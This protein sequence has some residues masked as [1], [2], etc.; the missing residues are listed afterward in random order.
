MKKI[1][2]LF[3]FS[4]LSLALSAQSL[5]KKYVFLEH[6]TNSPCPICASKNPAYYSLIKQ[7]P[8]DVRN[9]SIYSAVPYSSCLIYKANTADNSARAN[10]YDI[11]GSPTL[12]LNGTQLAPSTPLLPP[13]TLQAALNQ[14]SPISI[15]VQESGSNPTKNIQVKINTFGTVPAG[16]YKLFT[17]VAERT[18]L[19]NAPNGEK[20]HHDVQR[21][22]LPGGDGQAITLPATGES[23]TYNYSYTFTAPVGWTSNYDSLYAIAFVQNTLTG[24]VLNVGT[25][26]DPVFVGTG[27]ATPLAIQ[28]QPNPA[29]T[30]ARVILPNEAVVQI[31]VYSIGGQWVRTAYETQG[32]EVRIPVERLAPGIYLVKITGD[33]RLYVGKLVKN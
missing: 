2:F 25:R 8:N 16:D 23:A 6:F 15:E 19:Y 1:S 30:E 10:Y 33:T 18:V 32:T 17:A 4:A 12:I 24:E 26:F 21:D 13:A 28:I 7:Y 22:L 20:E 29:S 11:V 5:P 9:L 27:E 14:T 31:E 3:L